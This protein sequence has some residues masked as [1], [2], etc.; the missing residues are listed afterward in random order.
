MVWFCTEDGSRCYSYRLE[1]PTRFR[2]IKQAQKE[3]E[4]L[5]KTA[6]FNQQIPKRCWAYRTYRQNRVSWWQG[7]RYRIFDYGNL[8]FVD[9]L[10]DKQ[11]SETP[12]RI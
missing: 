5:N 8:K 12:L 6:W 10:E 2:H 11:N 4:R 9:G 3:L 1:H 7:H